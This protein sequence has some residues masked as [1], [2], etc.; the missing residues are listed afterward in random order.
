MNMRN[1]LLYS[2]I[3]VIANSYFVNKTKNKNKNKKHSDSYKRFSV[4]DII[5]TSS[6]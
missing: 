2:S 5:K 6:F 3:T 1:I 4:K